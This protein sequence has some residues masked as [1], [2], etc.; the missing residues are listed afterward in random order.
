MGMTR[1]SCCCCCCCCFLLTTAKAMVS[2]TPERGRPVLQPGLPTLGRIPSLNTRYTLAS[3]QTTYISIVL[4]SRQ[5]PVEQIQQLRDESM[6]SG[7][8]SGAL[9]GQAEQSPA[10][11][12]LKN[13]D[14]A[15]NRY[16]P[17]NQPNSQPSCPP[18]RPEDNE[19]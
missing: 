19:P 12:I 10:Q 7:L 4:L 3:R 18:T 11:Q 16:L 6:Y 5:S 1:Q 14:C 17:T 13:K 2:Q 8:P 9:S 15:E